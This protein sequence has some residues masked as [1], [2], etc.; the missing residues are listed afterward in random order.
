MFYDRST[1]ASFEALIECDSWDTLHET[2][3]SLLQERI[4]YVARRRVPENAVQDIVQETL[5][6]LLNKLPELDSGRDILAY[7]FRILRRVIGNYY[8][9]EK[10]LRKHFQP[11]TFEP[12]AHPF[13]KLDSEIYLDQILEKCR[14]VN[15][16]Y[17]KIIKMV[18]DGYSIEEIAVETGCSSNQALY[19]RIHRSRRLLKKIIAEEE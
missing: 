1:G 12:A 11:Q 4:A 5:L 3:L 13:E 9:T 16:D 18:R 14:Q 19:N 10:T 6:V 7:T 15:G 17:S 8:Q 2:V